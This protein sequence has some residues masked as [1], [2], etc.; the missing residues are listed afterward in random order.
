MR[1]TPRCAAL[2]LLASAIPCHA[3]GSAPAEPSPGAMMAFE[4]ALETATARGD[5]GFLRHA[6]ADDFAFTHGEAW[7]TGGKPSRG[8]T[9]ATWLATGRIVVKLK[10]PFL[11]AGRPECSVWFVRVYRAGDGGWEPVSRRTVGE[12][13]P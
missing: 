6:L 4:R 7:R 1:V 8:D 10:P 3:Q 13:A 9:K 5:T 2:L 12:S 11:T